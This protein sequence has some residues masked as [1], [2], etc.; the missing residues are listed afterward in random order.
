MENDIDFVG[1]WL[2]IGMTIA[3]LAAGAITVI[4][5]LIKRKNNK[6]HNYANKNLDYPANFQWNIHTTLHETL[7]EVR[8]KLDCARTQIVQFHN[9]GQF[10]DGISMKKFS[11]THESLTTGTA[12][13]DGKKD[14]LVSMFLDKLN[15]LRDNDPKL[16]VVEPLPESYTKQYFQ[17]S[18]IIAF[19]MLPIRKNKEIV[20][21]LM[22]QWCSWNKVD[23]ID[24][25][26]VNTEM[27]R[28]RNLIEIQLQQQINSNKNR[29]QI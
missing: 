24:E 21:Y 5:P 25:D 1:S 14:M 17:N 6:K 27:E 22:S 12:G 23:N 20:G 15:L 8:I 13:E 26:V 16:Y 4:I 11:V 3:A 9:T 10:L 29:R 19:S 2:E 7:T 28:S 18:T